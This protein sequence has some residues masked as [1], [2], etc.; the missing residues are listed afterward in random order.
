MCVA[1]LEYIRERLTPTE[2]KSAL[3]EMT[4]DDVAHRQEVDRLIREYSNQ[5]DE[6]KKKIAELTAQK[7]K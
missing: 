4:V 6:L 1:C 7:T 5:P 2:F 3:V